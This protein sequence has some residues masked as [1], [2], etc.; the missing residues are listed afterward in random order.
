MTRTCSWQQCCVVADISCLELITYFYGLTGIFEE[1]RQMW[2]RDKIAMKYGKQRIADWAK[3][4]W[5]HLDLLAFVLLVFAAILRFTIPEKDFDVARWFYSLSFMVYVLRFTQVF[6]VI[7]QLGPKIIMI[8]KMMIDLLFFVVILSM[9]ILIFGVVTQTILEPESKLNYDLSTS[10]VY[11]PYFQMYGEL[12]LEDYQG[13]RSLLLA[14]Y[15]ILTNVLLLNLLIAMFSYTFEKVQEK[16][17]ILWKY[18]YY[19]VVYEHFDRPY[20]P[21]IGT[22]IQICRHSQCAQKHSEKTGTDF[23]R[24]LDEDHNSKITKFVKVCMEKYIAA[25]RKE[26]NEDMAH[27]VTSTARR[28]DMVIE[29]LGDLRDDVIR[30]LPPSHGT[31]FA[32]NNRSML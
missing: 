28:L 30:Q 10:V 21:L 14:F 24:H 19:A 9:T 20:I 23:R 11:R 1:I 7:E 3:D 26:T 12:F 31:G 27:K 8:K 25:E 22:L 6:Y 17:E 5:N 4:F 16:S 13:Y 32:R 2:Y 18:N 29:Q 15:M